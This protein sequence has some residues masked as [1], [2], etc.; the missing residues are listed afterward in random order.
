M[1]FTTL[2]SH[3]RWSARTLWLSP[4]GTR[5]SSRRISPGDVGLRR[6]GRALIFT[7]RFSVVV[8]DVD[9]RRAGGGPTENDSPL[10]VNPD[11]METQQIPF[12]GFETVPGRR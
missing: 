12:Q 5:N 8:P 6:R 7:P 9:V 3:P 2:T 1:R 11:A 4:S 10:V